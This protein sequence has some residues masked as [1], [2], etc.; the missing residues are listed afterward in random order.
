MKWK[1]GTTEHKGVVKENPY[2]LVCVEDPRYRIAKMGIDGT[3]YDYSPSCAGEFLAH[4]VPTAKEA[5]AICER[6][7]QIMG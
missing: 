6:H 1:T 4:N 3:R 5:M 7:R 2:C